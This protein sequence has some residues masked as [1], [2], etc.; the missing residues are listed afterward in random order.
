MEGNWFPSY[1]QLG[2]WVVEPLSRTD[3][4][5]TFVESTGLSLP[6]VPERR[7]TTQTHVG[8]IVPKKPITH[9]QIKRA[10]TEQIN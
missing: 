1:V 5:D 2:F 3:G 7:L 9:W 8:H 4:E 10:S 6:P